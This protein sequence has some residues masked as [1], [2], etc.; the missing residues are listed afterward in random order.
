MNTT[1]LLLRCR[2]GDPAALDELIR[3]YQP[4]I[5]R[6]ALIVLDSGRAEYSMEDVRGVVQKVL[7]AAVASGEMFHDELDF[8]TWMYATGLKACQQRQRQGAHKPAGKPSGKQPIGVQQAVRELEEKLRLP[9]LLHYAIGL[10]LAEIARVLKLSQST[11]Q[12]RMV[13]GRENL[14]VLL[15]GQA[16]PAAVGDLAHELA[17]EWIFRRLDNSLNAESR[18]H[19]DQHLERCAACRAFEEQ[20]RL[21]D[22]RLRAELP[23]LGADRLTGGPLGS[24]SGAWLG[25]QWQQRLRAQARLRSLG[26]VLAVFAMVVGL[27][28]FLA[29]PENR[30][31]S[32]APPSF[33]DLNSTQ[34]A[35]A[36]LQ[37]AAAQVTVTPRA[38][39]LPRPEGLL[40]YEAS[41]NRSTDLYLTRAD[42]SGRALLGPHPSNERAPHPSPDHQKVAF[43]SNRLNFGEFEIYVMGVDGSRARLLTEI[44]SESRG[45]GLSS[46]GPRRG[47]SSRSG[48][49]GWTGEMAWSP[50]SRQLVAIYNNADPRITFEVAR[51]DSVD[52]SRHYE[53]QWEG[54]LFLIDV[55]TGAVEPLTPPDLLAWRPVWSPDGSRIFF[56]GMSNGD[57]RIYSVK[58]NSGELEQFGQVHGLLDQSGFTF[59]PDGSSLAYLALRRNRGSE[60]DDELHRVDLASGEDQII[61][62]IPN[63]AEIDLPLAVRFASLRWSPNGQHLAYAIPQPNG[64]A[65]LKMLDLVADA[66]L[67]A[68]ERIETETVLFVGIDLYFPG[69]YP[70]WSPDSRGMG[71]LLQRQVYVISAHSDTDIAGSADLVEIYAGKRDEIGAGWLSW[72]P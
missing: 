65:V 9:L 11:I 63:T 61:W 17:R 53:G 51:G 49:G 10:S 29:Q 25:E 39:S 28:S 38:T 59:S 3:R 57:T 16:N 44:G 14:R 40:L 1:S 50:D 70:V 33:A 8:T 54:Q 27:L 36:V 12:A 32:A 18:L 52:Q 43:L 21:L 66:T 60:R 15:E 46:N 13:H 47:R 31:S 72:M 58:P 23:L 34:T 41:D 68:G 2:E 37:S 19:L 7:V 6:L 62:T 24:L 4:V 35:L 55:D 30:T 48:E 22:R 26:P 42:A 69:H 71:F 64:Q 67:P 56:N 5:A 20:V 45:S